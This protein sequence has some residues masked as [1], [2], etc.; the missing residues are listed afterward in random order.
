MENQTAPDLDKAQPALQPESQKFV[1]IGILVG[2]V[3]SLLAI[4][5]IYYKTKLTIGSQLQKP[6][7][8]TTTAEVDLGGSIMPTLEPQPSVTP[9]KVSTKQDLINQQNTLDVADMKGVLTN[10]EKNTKD[11]LQFSQ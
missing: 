9:V 8:I 2:V 5:V 3:V 7:T 11:S 4:G 6:A 10:L 1:L